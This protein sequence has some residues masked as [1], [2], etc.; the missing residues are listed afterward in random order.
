M[1][2]LKT[3][4]STLI[5]SFWS[6][7]TPLKDTYI[8]E[9]PKSVDLTQTDCFEVRIKENGL[10]GSQVLHIDMPS[11]FTLY[12]S[13]GERYAQGDVLNNQLTYRKDEYEAKTVTLQ[14]EELDI[15]EWSGTLPITISV[16]N[17][18][19]S[20]I[21]ES[22]EDLNAL[23]RQYDPQEILFT[24][25][26]QGGWIADVSKAQDASINAYLQDR[27]IYISNQRQEKILTDISMSDA[28]RDLSSLSHIDLSD[29]DFGSCFDISYMFGNSPVLNAIEGIGQ[30]DVSNV[31]D[32]DH[33]FFGC[34][35]LTALQ[36]G[37]WDTS[38]V[39][40][41]S[42]VFA[43][44][45]SLK[46]LNLRTW[47]VSEGILFED[48]F[49]H[50]LVLASTGNLSA[51]DLGS[52]SD[53]S[54]MFSYCPKLRNVG[55]LSAW[56]TS[57]ITDLSGLF[58]GCSNLSSIGSVSSWDVRNVTSFASCFA[59]AQ[60][61]SDIGDLYHWQVSS[62]CKDLS[63]LFA[64]TKELLAGDPDLSS[65]DV[66]GCKNMSHMFE[67]CVLSSLN[68]Q[69]WDTS[70]LKDASYMFA[71]SET[72]TLSQLTEV[73]GIEDLDV[74]SLITI[75]HMF[76]E[77]QYFNADLSAWDTSSLQDLSYAFYGAYR[78][79]TGKLKHWNVSSVS[80]MTEAF[81]DQAGSLAQSE[82]PDWYH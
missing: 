42:G 29:L 44:C 11:G 20:N 38:K 47:D 6:L 5:L 31:T 39:T 30:I 66:S 32:M 69:G 4:L 10:N 28:F 16:E 26:V 72:L 27:T 76:Y 22:G 67:N 36:I 13:D 71:Y 73:C 25:T 33:L 12:E 56:N 2:C 57:Q 75:S 48:M 18:I 23:F 81:G 53:I 21:L 80:D 34:R 35:S 62:S 9:I 52:A 58:S 64:G 59:N 1:T 15:G 63:Y 17:T 45:E 78:F 46:T 49:S 65:W 43:Y 74:S 19:P 24:D 82:I 54:G 77:D 50:C 70:S 3:I 7:L 37:G 79:E 55:D 68:I 41:F 8:I 40:D 60:N 51:W 14:L 61:L